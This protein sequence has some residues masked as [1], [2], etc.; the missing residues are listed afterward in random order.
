MPVP[1]VAAAVVA[2]AASVAKA[3]PATV[4]AVPPAATA[5]PARAVPPA[6]VAAVAA[7]PAAAVAAVPAVAAAAP[8]PPRKPSPGIKDKILPSFVNTLATGPNLVNHLPA[9]QISLAALLNRLIP[10]ASIE[11][12]PKKPESI[13]KIPFRSLS[14]FSSLPPPPSR[15]KNFS[16]R[17][18]FFFSSFF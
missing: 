6:T 2:T 1:A 8:P 12:G 16:H 17:A 15:D 18:F 13:L 14:S 11:P 3:P 5:P 9:F 7:V 10:L 4:A